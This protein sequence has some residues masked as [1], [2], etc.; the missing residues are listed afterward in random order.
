MLPPSY[1]EQAC[2]LF[3]VSAM[4]Q[5][6]E[7]GELV[8]A[9]KQLGWRTENEWI[10]EKG[11]GKIWQFPQD[12]A[13]LELWYEFERGSLGRSVLRCTKG[14]WARLLLNEAEQADE[15]LAALVV[16]VVRFAGWFYRK[17]ARMQGLEGKVLTTLDFG[18]FAAPVELLTV[19]HLDYMG[20]YSPLEDTD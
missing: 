14:L 13:L 19:Y 17:I 15:K 16:D 7:D 18:G 3:N 5:A 11:I 10:P 9:A 12:M 20:G 2:R 1:H 6:K 4:L 8:R